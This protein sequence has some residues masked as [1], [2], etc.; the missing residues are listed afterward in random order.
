MLELRIEKHRR[1]FQLRA[2]LRLPEGGSLAVTGASGAGKS[3]LLAC[4]AGALPPD[5]GVIRWRGLALHPPPL[6]LARR[7]LGWLAQ[8]ERLFPH[9][10]VAGNVC[11]GLDR[12]ARPAAS[13]W[14]EELRA[15]LELE[16]IWHAPAA[17]VSGG[18]ARRVALARALA[19]RPPLLLLDEPFADQDAARVQ[20]II[21]ALLDWKRRWGW[22][23]LA[24]DH[25][26]PA[27]AQMTDQ[28]LLL[29]AGRI[30]AA[31][32]WAQIAPDLAAIQPPG[33]PR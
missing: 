13:A 31:G 6:P 20:A 29:Q 26:L 33:F 19:R 21:A 12:R 8:H 27:L 30:T 32:G 23:L 3:T 7:P 9:L 4:I 17:E 5:R 2:E 1:H 16:P 25:R 14:I 11:F 15:R 28:V 22:T 24:A 18:E 10:N